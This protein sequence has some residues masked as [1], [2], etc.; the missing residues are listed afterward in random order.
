MG[1]EVP[2]GL[3]WV[4]SRHAA[5]HPYNKQDGVPPPHKETKNYWVPNGNGAELEKPCPRSARTASTSFTKEYIVLFKIKCT[6]RT[7][8]NY[9]HTET[10]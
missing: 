8:N 10:I 6:K 2:L 9:K 7:V 3:C 5:D 4:E 1:E